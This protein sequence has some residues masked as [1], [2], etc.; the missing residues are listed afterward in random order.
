[1]RMFKLT[2]RGRGGTQSGDIKESPPDT[3][4]CVGILW[5]CSIHLNCDHST[6][7]ALEYNYLAF[8]F[9]VSM[10]AESLLPE[11]HFCSKRLTNAYRY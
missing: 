9:S 10:A 8:R 6:G 3:G 2:Y 7:T 1:M 5:N 4:R 11:S